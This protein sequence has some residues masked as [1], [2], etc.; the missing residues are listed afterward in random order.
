MKKIKHLRLGNCRGKPPGISSHTCTLHLWR[1][2][3]W[4]P[5]LVSEHKQLLASMNEHNLK[6]V[7]V[8]I[9]EHKWVKVSASEYE[10]VQ[11]SDSKHEWA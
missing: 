5:M 2:Y 10:Q 9:N 4:V 3:L 11:T 6:Q 1:V 7:P 8:S